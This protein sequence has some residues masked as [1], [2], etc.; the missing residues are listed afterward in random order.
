M[1]I[2]RHHFGTQNLVVVSSVPGVCERLYSVV[3]TVY[4]SAPFRNMRFEIAR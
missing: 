1:V 3:E 2:D 4:A